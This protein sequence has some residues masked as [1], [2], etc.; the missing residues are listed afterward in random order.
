[1]SSLNIFYLNDINELQA[2]CFGVEANVE[3]THFF[4]S[5]SKKSIFIELRLVSLKSLLQTTKRNQNP[6]F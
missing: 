1:M 4:K 6:F 2:F 3:A 5:Q